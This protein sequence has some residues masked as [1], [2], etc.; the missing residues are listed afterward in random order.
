MLHFAILI[1][2]VL[3]C[4]ASCRNDVS[5]PQLF[6][7]RIGNG[8]LRQQLE[9]IP[10]TELLPQAEEGLRAEYRNSQNSISVALYRMK[11]E[12]S[13]FEAVQTWKPALG[14]SVTWKRNLFVVY[15]FR[16]VDDLKSFSAAFLR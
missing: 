4:F 5:L 6:P 7:E 12:S 9:P 15:S 16:N 11:S 10:K 3:C 1:L 8:W 2:A 13:A 14:T